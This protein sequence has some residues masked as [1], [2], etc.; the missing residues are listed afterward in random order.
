MKDELVW[1]SVIVAPAHRAYGLLLLIRRTV[2]IAAAHDVL[3]VS[4]ATAYS[5]VV[6]LFPGLIVAAAVVTI[7]PDS[8]PFRQQMAEFFGR[9]LP[10]TV[11]PLLEASFVTSGRGAQT[12]SALFGSV[13]VSVL[14]RR[15]SC[16]PSWRAF[17]ARTPC[18]R[19]RAA[20]GVDGCAR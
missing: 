13:L 11:R 5:A 8:L 9:V 3:T 1:E 10:S 7:L 16:L 19:C 17:A 14:A 4:Q 2:L 6:A 12:A 20:F 18:R 15:M